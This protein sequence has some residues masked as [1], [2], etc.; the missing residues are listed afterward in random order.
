MINN[1]FIVY[2]ICYS[3]PYLDNKIDKHKPKCANPV[4]K[5]LYIRDYDNEGKQRFVPWGLTCTTCGVIVKEKFKPNLTPKEF[6]AKESERKRNTKLEE[7]Y[8]KTFEKL[9]GRAYSDPSW[10]ETLEWKRKRKIA[11]KLE[12]LQRKKLGPE[13]IS[14]EES[15]LRTRIRNLKD[16]YQMQSHYWGHPDNKETLDF[17]WDEKLVEQ[18]LNLSP[19][20]STSELEGIFN[21][22][23]FVID[24][25]S[26]RKFRTRGFVP[27]REKPGWL[28]YDK[29][30][31]IELLK[32]EA[33]KRQEIMQTIIKTRGIVKMA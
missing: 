22:P 26:K 31:Y 27:D 21:G 10:E 5:R 23:E 2:D 18:F 7:T 17:G 24:I 8:A 16:F 14:P 12:R 3:M 19:R 33:H 9:T 28:K 25:D 30:A 20:P 6:E 29:E 4:G 11:N 32:S 1:A 15:G 13:P